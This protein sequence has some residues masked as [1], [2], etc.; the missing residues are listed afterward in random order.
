MRARRLLVSWSVLAFAVGVA[1]V[2][3]DRLDAGG[4]GGE[5]VVSRPD[6]TVA[7][8][9][10]DSTTS[11]TSAPVEVLP[12]GQV[13]VLGQVTAV[14]LEG[15]VPDP[16]HV[17]A[18][19]TVTAERG[20]GNG[21]ELS[22]VVVDGQPSSIVWDGGRPF[23]LSSGDGLVLDPVTVDLTEAGFRLALG[24]SA[25]ALR[26]G[27]HQLDTPV[28]VGS[29][30]IATPHDQVRF[31]ATADSLFEARGDTVLMLGSEQPRRFLGPGLVRLD[32]TLT[33]TDAHGTGPATTLARS[34]ASFD[35][36]FTP[37]AG[38]GWTVE[39]VVDDPPA[40]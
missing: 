2:G 7:P 23:V 27:T 4:G 9:V 37:A 13:R 6:G 38:G 14:H 10:G 19:L 33:L 39:G 30:G 1:A 3:I 15:A 35:L 34:A 36:T 31:E 20:F 12:P 17:A 32:G 40:S 21:G 11:S 26:P 16:R 18:P 29:A 8:G 5:Q 22:S 24:G 25:H 28:A